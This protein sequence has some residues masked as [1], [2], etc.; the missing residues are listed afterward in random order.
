MSLLVESI[1]IENK[2]LQNLPYHNARMNRSRREYYGDFRKVDLKEIVN[3]PNDLTDEVYKCR[4][5][6]SKSTIE[7]I[8]F[9]V[10]NRKEI[11]MVRVV[12]DDFIDY[13]YKYADR[14]Q[15]NKLYEKRGH[16]EDIII[17]KQG[18]VTDAFSSNLVF[19]DGKNWDTPST[20]LL[21]GTRRQFLID[22]GLINVKPIKVDDIKNYQKVSF[23]NAMIDLDELSVPVGSIFF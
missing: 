21:K 19:Y 11:N 14:D 16:C 6:Y 9:L 5:V 17:I 15:L 13:T 18:F 8:E 2:Q 20:P 10:Y 23:I 7:K 12:H 3:I 22:N 1:K 4:V